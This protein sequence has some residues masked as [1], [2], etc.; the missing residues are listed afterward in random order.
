MTHAIRMKGVLIAL[1]ALSLS[2][3]AAF[4]STSGL[5]TATGVSGKTVPVA[6][7]P[8]AGTDEDATGT[9]DEQETEATGDTKPADTTDTPDT[10]SDTNCSTSPIG[11]TAEQ[12]AAMTHGQVVCWAAQQQTPDGFANH[13]AWVKS[14]ASGFG[15]SQAASKAA[16]GLAHKGQGTTHKP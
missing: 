8:E 10:T 3:G 4:A 2:A 12:L 15:G 6:T 7:K 1:V 14:W 5:S 16:A 13:G 9:P 11:L